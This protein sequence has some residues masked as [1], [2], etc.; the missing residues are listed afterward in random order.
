MSGFVRTGSGKWS[1][2]VFDLDGTLADTLQDLAETANAALEEQGLPP[3]PPEDYPQLVGSG[4]EKLVE[5]AAPSASAARREAVRQSFLRLY[6]ANCLRHTRP[7][8]GMPET[9]AALRGRGIPLLVVTNK[10][11]VQARAIVESLFGC[12]L[13]AGIY[14]NRDGRRV[15]PDPALTL[16]ALASV[17]APPAEALFVGDSDVDVL[18]ARNAGMRAA[19][20]VWGF[21]GEEELRRAGADFLLHK[22]AEILNTY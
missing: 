2:V 4:L 12:G 22:P 13:F 11:D 14:G 20:A 5:R 16:A 19:G 6:A 9:L 21:R 7:Y 1:A 15:K 17:G 10:P 3:R 18:T 8:D